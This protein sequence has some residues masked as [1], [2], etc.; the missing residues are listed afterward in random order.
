V[1]TI[2]IPLLQGAGPVALAVVSFALAF[3]WPSLIEP[4]TRLR[5]EHGR[6]GGF[7]AVAVLLLVAASIVYVVP[8]VLL[9][10]DFGAL[11]AAPLAITWIIVA[12]ALALRSLFQIGVPRV[13][14]A[15]FSIVSLFGAA[16]GV[17]IALSWHHPISATVLPTGAFVLVMGAIAGI[18][19]W[20]RPERDDLPAV[21]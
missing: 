11:V 21:A 6:L 2:L 12:V 8:G 13:V 17:L 7:A 16:A 20:A 10:D 1:N 5:S 15:A 18:V 19:A 14:S 9:S 3:T 4:V